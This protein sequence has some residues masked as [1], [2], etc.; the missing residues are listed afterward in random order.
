MPESLHYIEQTVKQGCGWCLVSFVG[1]GA[2]HDT[3][4]RI[5]Y[6]RYMLRVAV[7]GYERGLE[8]KF[9]FLFLCEFVV[10]NGLV[11][12]VEKRLVYFQ[13]LLKYL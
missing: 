4:H 9:H 5:A 13:L 6:D 2:F 12:S 10:L 3:F 8:L 11:E 7:H 1:T